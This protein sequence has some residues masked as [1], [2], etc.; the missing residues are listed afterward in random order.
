MEMQ[1]NAQKNAESIRLY[2]GHAK[3]CYGKCFEAGRDAGGGLG[4]NYV[5]NYIHMNMERR[6]KI[7]VAK[8]VPVWIKLKT[9]KNLNEFNECSLP[10][11]YRKPAIYRWKL[12]EKKSTKIYIGE[13]I[14]L[15]RRLRHY[16]KPGVDQKTNIWLNKILENGIKD[17]HEISFEILDFYNIQ[18]NKSLCIN[19][20]DMKDKF[21]RAFL[22][23]LIILMLA[24]KKRD[25]ILNRQISSRFF[26][27]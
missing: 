10:K 22:E 3:N 27:T 24:R 25:I 1:G 23:N 16:T 18:I 26:I 8:F 9:F 14:N 15:Q 12:K 11:E 5:I 20:A 13:T 6:K 2:T 7:D 21:T 17:R 19:L 4:V